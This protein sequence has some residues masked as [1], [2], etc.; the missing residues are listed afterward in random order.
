MNRNCINQTGARV[1]RT[2]SPSGSACRPRDGNHSGLGWHLEKIALGNAGTLALE[3][4][5]E[6]LT[7]RGIPGPEDWRR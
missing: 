4:G 5:L 7:S 3:P 1:E 6:V 2:R